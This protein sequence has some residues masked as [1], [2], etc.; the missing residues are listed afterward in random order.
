[1]NNKMNISFSGILRIPNFYAETCKSIK[2]KSSF[3]ALLD[4][5]TDLKLGFVSND[6]NLTDKMTWINPW[7]TNENFIKDIVKHSYKDVDSFYDYW[8]GSFKTKVRKII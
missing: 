2:N 7:N 3:E 4:I 8:S 6:V 5:A 1:M